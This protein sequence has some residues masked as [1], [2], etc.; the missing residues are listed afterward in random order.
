MEAWS[1]G[2]EGVLCYKNIVMVIDVESE[3]NNDDAESYR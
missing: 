2:F 1:R 3:W